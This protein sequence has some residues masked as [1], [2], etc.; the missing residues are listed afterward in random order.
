M[1]WWRGDVGWEAR[2]GV[3]DRD[4][5][6]GGHNGSNLQSATHPSLCV[7]M[8]CT[9]VTPFCNLAVATVPT[10]AMPVPL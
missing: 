8:V 9:S 2:A 4:A 10:A 6:R 7:V 3:E 5:T 1:L